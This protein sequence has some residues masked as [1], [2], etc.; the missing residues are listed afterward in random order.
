MSLQ[1]MVSGIVRWQKHCSL[2]S[3]A[4]FRD[5]LAATIPAMIELLRDQ[6][7]NIQQAAVSALVEVGKHGEWNCKM[8]EA[9]L[10]GICS[11]V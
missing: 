7:Y 10:I 4:E 5:A 1:S 2:E 6:D 9:L 3:A 8:A 11:S